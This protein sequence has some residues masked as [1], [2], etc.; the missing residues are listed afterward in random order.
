VIALTT[1]NG[2]SEYHALQVQYRRRVAQGLHALAAYSWSHS[3]DNDSSD[4]FLMWAGSGGS[5]RGSSDFD[6]RHSFSG[7]LSYSLPRWG[8]LTMD[9][10]LRARSGFP[11]TAL[12]R[13]EYLGISLANA[14]RPNLLLGVPVWLDDAAAAGGRRLNPAAFFGSKEGEQGSLGRNVLTG[15][16]MSQLDLAIGREFRL[17]ETRRL[18]LRAEAFN[19]LNHANF[20]DPVKFLNS[21]LFGQSVSMLNVMLGTG[22]PGSGLA[23][24]LQ[25][26]GPRSLQL[27]VRFQF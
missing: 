14:F 19:I 11:I 10:M 1:N 7:S 15:F 16:G 12:Q 22:S 17:H 4:A 23:P 8:G 21:P 27:S 3:I 9:A 5:D 25:T 6:V 13:E 20:G 2:E 18:Q 24:S 26:G